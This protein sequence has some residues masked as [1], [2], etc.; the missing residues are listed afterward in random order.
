MSFNNVPIPE[1]AKAAGMTNLVFAEDFETETAIDFSGEGKPGYSFYADRPYALPTLTP[2]ECQMRDSVL[3]FKPEKC[4]SAIG[5]VTYS[6]A[7]RNGFL[8]H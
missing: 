4:D 2:E 7:G 3:Y 6:K 8:M 1:A 5:L